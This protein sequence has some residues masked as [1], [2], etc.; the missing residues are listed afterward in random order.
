[1]LNIMTS[2]IKRKIIG[3]ILQNLFEVGMKDI[4]NLEFINYETTFNRCQ[5][6]KNMSTNTIIYQYKTNKD[7]TFGK[8]IIS[9]SS[10]LLKEFG[11]LTE[12]SI[13]GLLVLRKN[14][15]LYV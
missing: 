8:Y 6:L 12:L 9:A 7:T 4:N 5:V 1:M 13:F 15:N 11:D 3:D 2:K 14:I 10:E